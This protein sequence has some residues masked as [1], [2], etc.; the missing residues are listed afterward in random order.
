MN[1]TLIIPFYNED[2]NIEPLNKEII[3]NIKKIDDGKR[4][5]EIIYVDDGSIDNTF[6]ELKK[7]Y[8]N[9]L[10]Q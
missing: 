10:K 1:Y 6:N 8:K 4:K 9:L 2:R 3:N 5:F 7:L